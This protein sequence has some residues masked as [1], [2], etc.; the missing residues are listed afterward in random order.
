MQRT[1]LLPLLFVGFGDDKKRM[2]FFLS[3]LL[4]DL[5]QRCNRLKQEISNITSIPCEISDNCQKTVNSLEKVELRAYPIHNLFPSEFNI[6]FLLNNAWKQFNESPSLFP[7]WELE[8]IYK[9]KSCLT[10]R[11]YEKEPNA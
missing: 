5:L 7:G 8:Q 1:I 6:G 2:N 11:F 10:K 4:H 3:G 9:L